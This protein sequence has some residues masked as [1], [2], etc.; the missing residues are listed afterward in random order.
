MQFA[1]LY[2]Q[3]ARKQS[4]TTAIQNPVQYSHTELEAVIGTVDRRTPYIGSENF[5][6][7]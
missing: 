2:Q 1:S 6:V 4:D 7:F 3:E 5:G